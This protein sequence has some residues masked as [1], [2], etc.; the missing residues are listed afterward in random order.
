M[1]VGF[2]PVTQDAPRALR[3]DGKKAQHMGRDAPPAQRWRASRGAVDRS[4]QSVGRAEASESV[5]VAPD[6]GASM[7]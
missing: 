6:D 1:P 4:S 5:A 2:G 3:F 7:R